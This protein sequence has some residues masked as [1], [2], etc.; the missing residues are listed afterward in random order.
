VKGVDRGSQRGRRADKRRDILQR[1]IGDRTG[2]GTM[3]TK[4]RIGEWEGRKSGPMKYGDEERQRKG[5]G[6]M[7]ESNK[8]ESREK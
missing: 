3:T 8:A 5:G 1:R 6:G 2:Q 4:G 7:R